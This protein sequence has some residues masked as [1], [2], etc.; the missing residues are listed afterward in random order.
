[1]RPSNRHTHLFHHCNLLTAKG[2]VSKALLGMAIVVVSVTW[3]SNQ[4]IAQPEGSNLG[5]AIN[6]DSLKSYVNTL[7]SKRMAGRETGSPGCA[8]AA[9][10][11]SKRLNQYGVVP[12]FAKGS[13]LQSFKLRIDRIDT[14]TF[15]VGNE[16]FRY[17]SDFYTTNNF[18]VDT[19]K[20]NMLVFAG[21]GIDHED[22]SDLKGLPIAGRIAMVMEGEPTDDQGRSWITRT[23]SLTPA[24]EA[25][26]IKYQGLSRQNPQ[27]ILLISK[28]VERDIE[29]ITPR[30][31]Q[32]TFKL[33]DSFEKGVYFDLSPNPPVFR[34]SVAMANKLIALGKSQNKTRYGSVEALQARIRQT[35]LPESFSFKAQARITVKR[36]G[37]KTT[38]ENVAGYVPGRVSPGQFVI[39]SAHYDHLGARDSVYYPG[40]DD[41][42]SGTSAI[43][44]MARIAAEAKREGF[45]PQR[46]LL[47]VFFSGEEKGLLGSKFFVEKDLAIELDSIVAVQNVDMIGRHDN[48]HMES[49]T[50]V[51]NQPQP[52]LLDKDYLYLLGTNRLSTGLRTAAETA[53]NYGA[54]LSLDYSFDIKDPDNLFFRSDHVHFARHFIPCTFYFSGLHAD[55]HKPSD[56]ADRLDFPLM[57]RRAMFIYDTSRLLSDSP[58][59]LEMD[60]PL[61]KD[62]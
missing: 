31:K 37:R 13:Y 18:N 23:D 15:T 2:L 25:W 5:Q 3:F 33:D 49:E 26:Q 61:P 35:G 10:F 16:S 34:I 6:V 43:L 44:E 46:S 8:E 12:L 62:L 40:A 11:L 14:V 55:Y 57:R 50:S 22:Y 59:R 58:A 42:V 19:I 41:N 54:G 17:L 20:D 39:L 36:T 38:S 30:L 1:M 56:T 52:R 27:A 9:Q 53:N 60:L 21:Y 51:G 24:G 28:T 32:P 47:F 29:R 7:T 45:G 4:A 48:K